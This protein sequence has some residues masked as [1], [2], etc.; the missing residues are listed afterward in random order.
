MPIRALPLATLALCGAAAHAGTVLKMT[1][2]ELPG[3]AETITTVQADSGKLRVDSGGPE[4]TFVIFKN[5]TLYAVNPKERSYTAMDRES[6]KK[7]ADT[8]N[9][10]LKQMQ[11]RLASM[12]PEQRAQI[13]KMMG[14]NMP[15][16]SKQA[17]EEIRQTGKTSKVAGYSCTYSEVLQNGVVVSELCIVPV[18]KLKGGQELYATS[19]KVTAL[20]EDLLKDLEAPWLKQMVSR[21]ME[22]Y[23]KLGGIPVHSRMFENGQAAREST[24]KSIGSEPV[25]ASNFEV[26]SGF[27]RK[28]MMPR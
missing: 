22:N 18:D 25:A 6:M 15:G 20:M 27:T 9:P 19:V 16:T 4:D 8:I 21:Q 7:M 17:D 10:A 14:G 3:G 13:E 12:P 2:R 26:P 24:L 1:T 11:E 5:D 28:E 23:G